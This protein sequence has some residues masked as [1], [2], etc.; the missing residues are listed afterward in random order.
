[1]TDFGSFSTQSQPQPPWHMWG[2]QVNWNLVAPNAATAL[3][4]SSLANQIARVNYKRPETWA[5]WFSARILDHTV[6]TEGKAVSVLFDIVPGIGRASFD[7]RVPSPP[8]PPGNP[9]PAFCTMRWVISPGSRVGPADRKYTTQV[10]GPALIDNAD[11]GDPDQFGFLIDRIVAED[12]QVMATLVVDS[13]DAP[14]VINRLTVEA[15]A[16]FAPLSHIRPDWF[17][18]QFLGG[19]TGGS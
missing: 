15:Q 19:E 13:F 11:P 3:T 8:A 9:Q 10:R 5:F 18:D 1:M 6:Q 16:F 2:G 17:A 4:S 14:L 7:T 12:L